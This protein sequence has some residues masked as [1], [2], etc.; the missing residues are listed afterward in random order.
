MN[1]MLI[2]FTAL[3]L[4]SCAGNKADNSIKEDE[5][6]IAFNIAASDSLKLA[7]V[8]QKAK[9]GN[10]QQKSL[11]EI[12]MQLAELFLETPY[13]AN[14]LDQD[15][16]EKL[17]INLKGFDC[18]TY[19]ENVLAMSLTI[20]SGELSNPAFAQHLLHLRYRNGNFDG[21]ASRLHYFS[22]WLTDN[23]QKGILELVSNQIGRADLDTK[24]DIIS[25]NW[26]TNRFA[27]NSTLLAEI[28]SVETVVSKSNLKYIS[29]EQLE[30]VENKIQAG[31]IIALTTSIKGLDVAHT[32]IA[33]R[34]NG[35]LHLCHASSE[36]GKVVISELPLSEYLQS[37]K[38]FNGILVARLIKN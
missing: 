12:E 1:R 24:V 34:V 16:V 26:N 5:T 6:P 30:V 25:R 37:K 2:L 11:A 17:V 19:V 38:R 28:K 3:L 29:K 21:Y 35:R 9:N 33:I 10:W 22:E 23:Q 20:K 13:V 8:W 18:V 32:G 27:T 4:V 31:D 7:E 14:T 15:S 36:L